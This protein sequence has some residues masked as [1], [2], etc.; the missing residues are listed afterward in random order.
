[1]IGDRKASPK[2]ERH[3]HS[4]R[5]APC[6][7]RRLPA[8]ADASELWMSRSSVVESLLATQGRVS[9]Q[10]LNASLP[11]GPFDLGPTGNRLL[12]CRGTVSTLLG[13]RSRL[14]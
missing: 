8:L 7:S 11:E 12:S 10:D 13:F 1:M 5:M 2:I 14:V 4:S 9:Q 3:S 6:V